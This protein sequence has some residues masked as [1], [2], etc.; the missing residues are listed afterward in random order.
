MV[1][2]DG[3]ERRRLRRTRRP[4]PPPVSFLEVASPQGDRITEKYIND[5][6]GGHSLTQGGHRQLMRTGWRTDEP[7]Q[8]WQ[9]LIAS[10]GS[11]ADARMGRG[12]SLANPGHGIGERR[13]SAQEQRRICRPTAA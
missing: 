7:A 4:W 3:R 9:G 1:V 8:G 10:V 11:H 12:A 6:V 5:L 2:S 13:D